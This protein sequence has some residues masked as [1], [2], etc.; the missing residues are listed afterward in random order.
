MLSYIAL[1]VVGLTTAYAIHTYRCF[2]VN[3]AAAKQSGI[4]YICESDHLHYCL[5]ILMFG[6]ARRCTRSIDSGSSRTACGFHFWRGCPSRGRNRGLG[7]LWLPP[8]I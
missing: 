2:A 8:S 7:K 5:H 3:L 6:Q 4:P 1:A